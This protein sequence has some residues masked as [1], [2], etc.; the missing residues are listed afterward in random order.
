MEMRGFRR[1]LL[2]YARDEVDRALADETARV[3]R[4]E[5]DA[6]RL[7]AK[8]DDRERRLQKALEELATAREMP[9][10]ARDELGAPVEVEPEAGMGRLLEEI[11]VEAVRQAAKMGDLALERS[12]RATARIR[13][14]G[15]LGG[16]VG[17]GDGQP[18]AAPSP[19]EPAP[20]APRNHLPES[21]FEGEVEVE[22]GPLRDFAQLSGFEDAA[23]SIGA[24]GEIAVKGFAGGRVTLAVDL[25]E[26]VELL[27]ELEERAPL[28]FRVRSLKKDRVVLD[29]KEHEEPAP[30]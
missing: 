4:L 20:A 12:V 24:T 17:G 23:N 10:D 13:A 22:I 19:A 5:S 3:R 1:S 16:M 15:R 26:P 29:V 9:R 8:L 21:M 6:K 11:Y 25:E 30:A 2:G 7:G 27:R 28:E 14:L 18:A